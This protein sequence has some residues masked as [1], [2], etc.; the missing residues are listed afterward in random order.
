MEARK[1][2][3]SE[4]ESEF[5]KQTLLQ[6][7]HPG[8]NSTQFFEVLESAKVFI[9]LGFPF[10]GPSPIEALQ[11][12]CYFINPIWEPPIGRVLDG[13]NP[14]EY[15]RGFFSGKPT[16]RKLESQVP[17]LAAINRQGL[18]RSRPFWTVESR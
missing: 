7:N 10:E 11:A 12:G 17:Y 13:P 1:V 8:L 3:A 15:I 16:I 4:I 2:V 14:K 5:D 9:G 18:D 6:N